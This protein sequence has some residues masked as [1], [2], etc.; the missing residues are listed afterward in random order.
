MSVRLI[1]RVVH[2]DVSLFPSHPA[3]V[4]DLGFEGFPD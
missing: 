1:D 4:S 3:I 2:E